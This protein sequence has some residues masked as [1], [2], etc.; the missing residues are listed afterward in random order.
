MREEGSGCHCFVGRIVSGSFGVR[1]QPGFE[2]GR[3]PVEEG[4]QL[5]RRR[6]PL[7][8]KNMDRQRVFLEFFKHEDERA[9]AAG[10][11]DKGR[12]G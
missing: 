3:D 5:E 12:D 6:L 4:P 11:L 1:R 2:A 7:R 8:I 10:E 9:F